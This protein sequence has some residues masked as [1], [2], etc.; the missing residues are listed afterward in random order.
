MSKMTKEEEKLFNDNVVLLSD[1]KE[2]FK[3]GKA[4]LEG[5]LRVEQSL[6]NASY[7]KNF[8]FWFESQNTAEVNITGKVSKKLFKAHGS[9][10]EAKNYMSY[11]LHLISV[12]TFGITSY[13]EDA[14]NMQAIANNETV[15]AKFPYDETIPK[16]ELTSDDII[17]VTIPDHRE[18][19]FVCL[20]TEIMS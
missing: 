8:G 12:G 4:R 7:D 2:S 1:R 11:L 16:E 5:S 17:V 13:A 14:F 6:K 3:Q 15:F 10:Q 9:E 18:E 19:I 20:E